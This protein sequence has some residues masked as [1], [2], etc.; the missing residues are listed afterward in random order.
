MRLT[1]RIQQNIPW[2]DVAMQNAAGGRGEPPGEL[3][4]QLD[5]LDLSAE[6]SPWRSAGRASLLDESHAEKWLSFAL[7]D[8]GGTILDHQARHGLGFGP[9][10]LRKS[11]EAM[12]HH[13]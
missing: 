6:M 13:D 9:E 5:G 12:A 4:H 1:L 2:F 11:G 3:R 7:T 10:A 8:R